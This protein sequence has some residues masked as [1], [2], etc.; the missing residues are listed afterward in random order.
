MV[1]HGC[2]FSLFRFSFIM[3]LR[4]R[5]DEYYYKFPSTKANGGRD[6]RRS[7]PGLAADVVPL[8]PLLLYHTLGKP[9]PP[10]PRLLHYVRYR[11]FSLPIRTKI[12]KRLNEK[13]F[14]HTHGH[15]TENNQVYPHKTCMIIRKAQSFHICHCPE[16]LIFR[17]NK[18]NIANPIKTHW[19]CVLPPLK[20]HP[21]KPIGFVYSPLWKITHQAHRFCVLPP[22]KNHPSKP[23]GF[24]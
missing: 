5:S 8:R 21:S 11:F 17:S 23:I 18:K 2:G 14:L 7:R 15:R 20:N 9:P 16:C 19:F 6:A 3:Q 24:M 12:H 13:H 10:I 22:L 4:V 1:T